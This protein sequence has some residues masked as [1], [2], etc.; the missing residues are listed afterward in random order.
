[1][2]RDYH[3]TAA[4]L[5]ERI[6]WA[7]R[8]SW[9]VSTWGRAMATSDR[10][11]GPRLSG[12][13]VLV[14]VG[15][16]SWPIRL[17]AAG[18]ATPAEPPPQL[19]TCTVVDEAG[20]P[21]ANVTV[22][23][24]KGQATPAPGSA[25]R[26][27]AAGKVTL[28]FKLLPFR[29][30]LLAQD[31]AGGRSG[32]GG[33]L[34]G[35]EA[36]PPRIV[37]RKPRR[38]A[39]QVIDGQGHPVAGA[40]VG[41]ARTLASLIT[42]RGPVGAGPSFPFVAAER[43]TDSAG[44]AT[45]NVPVGL[46]PR[47]VY[48]VKDGVGFDYFAFRD[49]NAETDSPAALALGDSLA[50]KFALGG[51]HR[52][53]VHVVD[54]RHRP[55]AK[56]GVRVSLI[57]RPD[58]GGPARL[59]GIDELHAA[60]DAGGNAELRNIP[61]EARPG[62][63]IVSATPGYAFRAVPDFDPKAAVSDLQIVAKIQP[64]LDVHVT[65]ADGRPAIGAV[66]SG[67]V[68][69]F[70]GGAIRGTFGSVCDEQGHCH[71][72]SF[73]NDAYCVVSATSG[74]RLSPLASVLVRDEE[75]VAPIHLVI[76]P[77]TRVHGTLTSPKDHRPAAGATV[78]LFQSDNGAF[79]RLPLDRLPLDADPNLSLHNTHRTK[80]DRQG[81]FE[82]FVPQGQYSIADHDVFH[83]QLI[84]LDLKPKSVLVDQGLNAFEVRDAAEM[85]IKLQQTQPGDVDLEG[86][87]VLA[88]DPHKGVVRPDVSG[89]ALDAQKVNHGFGPGG[90]TRSHSDGT[91]RTKRLPC[92]MI[93]QAKSTKGVP[94]AGLAKIGPDET[95]VTITV[96]P[97]AT[98]RGVLVN[99][100]TGQPAANFTLSYGLRLEF[101][102][103]GFWLAFQQFEITDAK[104]RFQLEGLV[105]GWKYDVY[106]S[107]T[108]EGPSARRSKPSPYIAVG[109]VTAKDSKPINLGQLSLRFGPLPA[110]TNGAK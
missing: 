83:A 70:G 14:L 32:F 46:S 27:D 64:A 99:P 103:Q 101:P 36:P 4:G 53:R 96:A 45:L 86:R 25:P 16:F 8:W 106:A 108:P 73:H 6:E 80:T 22:S 107:R 84:G 41:V 77:T 68:E 5:G 81:R 11:T 35:P 74:Q 28:R 60:T 10:R 66:V 17:L 78:C 63:M 7:V 42:N 12:W 75:P 102:R 57:D 2:Q 13:L 79:R 98:A 24:L 49:P 44:K 94:L 18:T 85:E 97:T 104:G 43:V 61:T 29:V 87:V 50:V 82:F 88:S 72:T 34:T 93:V 33:Y 90:R 48:A 62:L 71:T 109:D 20:T 51:V 9:L 39:A 21:V 55:L 1:M 110:S 52:M 89:C 31:D 91:F 69:Y 100:A 19:L 58:R 54:K 59:D 47:Y 3:A 76:A 65:F 92:A 40:T 38:I 105:P 37:L 23:D 26:S 95:K 67:S 56:I 15:G 30:E